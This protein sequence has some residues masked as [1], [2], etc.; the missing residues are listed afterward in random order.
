MARKPARSTRGTIS[1]RPAKTTSWRR[2]VSTRAMPKL[3]GRLPP[4]DQL[5]QMILAMFFLPDQAEHSALCSR[6]SRSTRQ[7]EVSAKQLPRVDVEG[8]D[9]RIFDFFADLAL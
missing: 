9:Q 3:G 1:G 8:D 7:A 5:S 4:P 6:L 2:S